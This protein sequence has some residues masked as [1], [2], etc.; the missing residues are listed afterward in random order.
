MTDI[1]RLG[2]GDDA[3]VVAAG[4][5]FDNAPKQDA[6]AR[7]LADERNHLLVAYADG[8]PVGFVT[9]VELTHPDKGTEMF[10]YEL[11]VDPSHH[12]R[13]IGGSLVK[14]LGDIA[15]DRGCYDMWV[16]TDADNEAALQTYRRSGANEES[17]HVMLTW[18][19]S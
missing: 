5:L 4:H 13:G 2:P 17:T 14:A 18:P 10:L 19:L 7:F 15:H 8:K 12:R 16:L 3:L 1:R 11:A 6:I 9:G